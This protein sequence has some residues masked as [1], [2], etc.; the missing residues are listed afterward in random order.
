M[1]WTPVI[2]RTLPFLLKPSVSLHVD[3][4]DHVHVDQVHVGHVHVL[5]CACTFTGKVILHPDLE[6]APLLILANK[7]DRPVSVEMMISPVVTSCDVC[8]GLLAAD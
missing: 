7:Q 3:H 5:S 4:V 1:W 2:Q 6:G 8:P